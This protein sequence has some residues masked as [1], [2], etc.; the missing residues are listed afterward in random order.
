[1]KR[2]DLMWLTGLL[3]GEGSFHFHHKKYPQ[4]A[5]VMTDQDTVER[6]ASLMGT[7]A[8]REKRDTTSGG[9]VFRCSIAGPK[10][11]ML[12]R[13]MLPQMGIR[14]SKRIRE[15][16]QAF[17]LENARRGGPS[18]FG[19]R[20]LS[21]QSVLLIRELRRRGLGVNRIAEIAG[22]SHQNIGSIVNR[23]SWKH[24]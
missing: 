17:E 19:P 6:A 16:I 21:A 12:M 18:K 10:A 11:I 9:A 8:H 14:R 2:D 20:K 5:L 4:I 15:L 23:R 1:M 3:E 13:D 22:M 24:I 7:I